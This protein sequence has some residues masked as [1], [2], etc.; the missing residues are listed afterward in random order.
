MGCAH[1]LVKGVAERNVWRK[2]NYLFTLPQT[3]FRLFDFPVN[4]KLGCGEWVKA[5][6]YKGSQNQNDEAGEHTGH[7]CVSGRTRI[8]KELRY[9]AT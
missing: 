2:N 6:T 8:I 7:Q 9:P 1:S 5:K 4:N 3:N